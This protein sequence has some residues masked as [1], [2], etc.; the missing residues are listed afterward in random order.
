METSMPYKPLFYVV[1]FQDDFIY[2]KGTLDGCKHIVDTSYGGLTIVQHKDLT[3]Q[4]L[5]QIEN[6]KRNYG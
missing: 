4:M 2:F 1:D 6:D 3:P 5:N